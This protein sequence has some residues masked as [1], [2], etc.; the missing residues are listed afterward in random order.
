MGQTVAHLVETLSYKLESRG[1]HSLWCYW[2]FSLTLFL[3]L[4]YGCGVNLDSYRNEYQEY[5]LGERGG[6]CIRLATLPH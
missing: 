6:R 5:L 4:R 2:K 1:F 3:R